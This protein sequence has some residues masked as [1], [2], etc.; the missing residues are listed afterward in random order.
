MF[1]MI[2]KWKRKEMN[3][4]KRGWEDWQLGRSYDVH[5]IQPSYFLIS[6]IKTTYGRGKKDICKKSGP[7]MLCTETSKAEE[8]MLM[9]LE[10]KLA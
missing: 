8:P 6:I 5:N 4:C 1:K 7:Y 3:C 10:Q 2:P 9:Y